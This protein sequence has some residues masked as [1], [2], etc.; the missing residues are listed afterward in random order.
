MATNGDIVDYA[1]DDVPIGK[2]TVSKTWNA[3]SGCCESG[4]TVM[5][6][7]ASDG[8]YNHDNGDNIETLD[9]PFWMV[10]VAAGTCCGGFYSVEVF[11]TKAEADATW[12]EAYDTH[13]D[14]DVQ[15]YELIYWDDLLNAQYNM[16]GAELHVHLPK[17]EK[18]CASLDKTD[19]N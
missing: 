14:P 9:G 2:V 12:D 18:N 19:T 11:A 1:T 16:N 15:L 13:H 17:G 4:T 8:E 3:E 10:S 5:H 7:S 6:V